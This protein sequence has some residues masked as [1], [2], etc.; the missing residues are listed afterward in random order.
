MGEHICPNGARKMA[1]GFQVKV[2]TALPFESCRPWATWIV[3]AETPLEA[4]EIV[5]G[6]ASPDCEISITNTVAQHI[7]SKYNLQTGR[8]KHL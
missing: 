2:V 7:I 1:E 8:A 4:L 5:R 3:V 6:K